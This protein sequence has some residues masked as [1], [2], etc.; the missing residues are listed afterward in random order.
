MA[1]V[2]TH[3]NEIEY[4]KCIEDDTKAAARRSP[5]CIRKTRE[6][7]GK[8]R[9]SIW[10]MEFFHLQCGTWFQDNDTEF[11]RSQHRAV[12]HVGLVCH[13]IEF[14]QTSAILAFYFRFRFRPDHRSL[15]VILHQ[16]AKFYPKN[17]VM[18]I[19]MGPIM[20]SLKSPCIRLPIGRQWRP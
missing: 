6:K 15:H 4:N 17:D 11:A 9:F 1:I 16:S 2:I 3:S 19:L 8:K 18:S 13:T 5:N 20:G 14:A 12:W 10:W 7:N